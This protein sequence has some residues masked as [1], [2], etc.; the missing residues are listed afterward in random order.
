MLGGTCGHPTYDSIVPLCWVPFHSTQ[1]T[2]STTIQTRLHP[3]GMLSSVALRRLGLELSV[4]SR[5]MLGSVALHPTYKL[6]TRLHF[7]DVLGSVALH[8]TY[9]LQTRLH[10]RDVGFRCTP[11]NLQTTNS[12]TL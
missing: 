1:P 9:K 10:F 11:P 3:L 6:Q 5:K 4:H 7:R 12:V 2:I 8:P